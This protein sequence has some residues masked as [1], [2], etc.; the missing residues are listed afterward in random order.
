[1]SLAPLSDDELRAAR[2]RATEARRHR[3]RV[4]DDL[5]RGQVSLADVLDL[6]RTDDVVAQTRVVDVL[7]CLP[8]VGDKKAR[9]AMSRLDIAEN[10]RLRGLGR[11][12]VKGLKD[13]F[14]DD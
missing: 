10:R 7:K 9:A 11:H 3:A 12:Q 1:M 5:R 2:A 14:G 4:K 6:A 8:R 13:E